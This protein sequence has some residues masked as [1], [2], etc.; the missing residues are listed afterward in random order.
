MKKSILV[1]LFLIAGQTVFGQ[2]PNMSEL[3]SVCS[4]QAS[5]AAEC[6]Q[7]IFD[8]FR[9]SNQVN[10]A[11]FFGGNTNEA[12]GKHATPQDQNMVLGYNTWWQKQ[13]N[14]SD[15]LFQNNVKSWYIS[16]WVEQGFFLSWKD[17]APT[18]YVAKTK[19]YVGRDGSGQGGV[20]QEVPVKAAYTITTDDSLADK[21]SWKPGS[22]HLNM[23]AQ[24][25]EYSN[26]RSGLPL[27]TSGFAA[28]KGTW[29]ARVAFP[30][31]PLPNN[32]DFHVIDGF[33][34]QPT[35]GFHSP[36]RPVFA[37]ETSYWSELNTEITNIF[38]FTETPAVLS[39][40]G[41]GITFN[42]YQ[43]N[44]SVG[45][46]WSTHYS[47][48][49]QNGYINWGGVRW[50]CMINDRNTPQQDVYNY[51]QCWEFVTNQPVQ[52]ST[53]RS[54]I[55][56][57]VNNPRYMY[58]MFKITDTYSQAFFMSRADEQGFAYGAPNEP[59]TDF[60]M[61]SERVYHV[62]PPDPM[63]ATFQVLNTAKCVSGIAVCDITKTLPKDRALKTDYFIYT[64]TTETDIWALSGAAHQIRNSLDNFNYRASTQYNIT[65]P[66][67]YRINTTDMPLSA[68]VESAANLSSS[69]SIDGTTWNLP[70]YKW[71]FRIPSTS[72]NNGKV[73]LPVELI[74]ARNNNIELRQGGFTTSWS[75]IPYYAKK[76]LVRPWTAKSYV[77]HNVGKALE[78]PTSRFPQT[79]ILYGNL[80]YID[81]T[82]VMAEGSDKPS[83]SLDDCKKDK[84][85]RC[86]QLDPQLMPYTY[87]QEYN[88]GNSASCAVNVQDNRPR[89]PDTTLVI[90]DLNN[91][92]VDYAQSDYLP[93][94]ASPVLVKTYRLNPNLSLQGLISTGGYPPSLQEW[95]KIEG[96]SDLPT[97]NSIESY[98]N[99]VD[100]VAKIH[101]ALVEKGSVQIKVYD[102]LGREVVQLVDANH[103]AG[104]HQTDLDVSK[105][106]SGTYFYKIVASNG[107]T[108]TK[109]LVVIK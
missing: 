69:C 3:P 73:Y 13:P 6:K 62:I 72:I 98:P 34:L 61:E 12:Y 20:L 57:D 88:V 103:E 101:Y 70:K 33:W 67:V 78:I 80:I 107:Y 44:I 53:G 23:T 25:G 47:T 65:D 29:M 89:N 92:F 54:T 10:P 45:T 81:I 74:Q 14:S 84:L 104:Y 36:N 94:D 35:Y 15:V 96:T 106:S 9:Y 91:P 108:E 11:V 51:K 46:S 17:W 66:P 56:S 76:G 16:D 42:G 83:I 26:V 95:A 30:K 85:G 43:T 31:Q 79:S 93:L 50:K 82:V 1:V 90:S 68:P 97:E 40:T 28:N 71:D 87:Y 105:L 19:A 37:G 4:N 27:V 58:V 24:T 75:V 52:F 2:L 109:S 18:G 100:T 32:P 86:H 5:V 38:E 77:E 102:V 41:N 49:G 22:G 59:Y 60:W 63:L 7:F 21:R 48:T 55:P 39:S 8:D 64:P 99:P